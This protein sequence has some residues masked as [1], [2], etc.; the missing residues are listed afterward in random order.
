[1]MPRN[2]YRV[3][4]FEFV[5]KRY[6]EIKLDQLCSG[7]KEPQYHDYQRLII[8]KRFLEITLSNVDDLNRQAKEK[9]EMKIKEKYAGVDPEDLTRELLEDEEI[10]KNN[11]T[12]LDIQKRK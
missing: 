8:F 1:M 9:Y 7:K 2:Y 6:V 12:R 11:Q 4:N 3:S 10:E 5:E